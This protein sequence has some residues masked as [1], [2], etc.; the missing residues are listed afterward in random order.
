MLFQLQL[1]LAAVLLQL[2]LQFAVLLRAQLQLADA[3]KALLSGASGP[4]RNLILSSQ[5]GEPLILI[6]SGPLTQ[7]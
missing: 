4:A 2:Q 5:L 6:N 3:T 7:S 1:Q